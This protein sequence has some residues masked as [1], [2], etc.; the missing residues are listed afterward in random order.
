MAK[1]KEIR[2]DI[3]TTMRQ[4]TIPELQS[5]SLA[6]KKAGGI[7]NFLVE[8]NAIKLYPDGGVA[9]QNYIGLASQGIEIIE[10]TGILI[11]SD[12]PKDTWNYLINQ[13]NYYHSQQKK[14]ENTNQ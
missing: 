10:G 6:V 4:L 2:P 12:T 14:Y 11:E 13:L 1:E 9:I 5:L 3:P 7:D 8:Q